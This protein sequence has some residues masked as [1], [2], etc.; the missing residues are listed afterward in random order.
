MLFN[1]PMHLHSSGCFWNVSQITFW[2][3][4]LD[5]I[6]IRLECIS[7]QSIVSFFFSFFL[8]FFFIYILMP[9]IPV[10]FQKPLLQSLV[11]RDPQKSNIASYFLFDFRVKCDLYMFLTAFQRFIHYYVQHS[12]T[13]LLT[14]TFKCPFFLS[15]LL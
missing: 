5:Q 2:S 12:G 10:S 4:L 6:V 7:G 11:L 13:S 8:R 14:E 3:V 15:V 1:K 9:F